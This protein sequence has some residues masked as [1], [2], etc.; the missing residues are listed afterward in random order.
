MSLR[1]EE[2]LCRQWRRSARSAQ[3]SCQH[4]WRGLKM[5]TLPC[6]RIAS[7]VRITGFDA[8]ICA[9]RTRHRVGN[10]VARLAIAHSDE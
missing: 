3:R 7:S 9:H 6:E 10:A 5:L 4:S 8:F 1:L 2:E